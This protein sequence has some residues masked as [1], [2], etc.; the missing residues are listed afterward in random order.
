MATAKKLPSGSWRCQVYS[1]NEPVF[2][3]NGYPV[4]DP[5]TKRQKQKRIYVSF[6][7]D[8]PSKRGKAEAEHAAAEYQLN[9]GKNNSR[10]KQKSGNMT[11][12]NAM[13][14][15]IS[16]TQ[17]VLSG[18]TIQGYKKE[19]YDSYS[20]LMDKKLREITS[21]DLQYAVDMDTKRVSKRS[22]KNKKPISPKTVRNTFNYVLTVI[23]H[24]YPGD[25]YIVKLPTVPKKVKELL[26]AQTV[27]N[28]IKGTDIELPCLLACW[29][30]FSMSEIRGI[31]LKDISGDYI[32][33]NQV[34]VD[35][36]CT[37]T[38]KETGKAEPRLRKHRIPAYIK[39]LI[40]K[41]IQNAT[42]Q[43]DHLIKLSGHGIYMRWKRLLAQN[44]LPHIKF[45]D[46]RHLNASV[47]ALLRIPDKYAQERGG[48]ASDKV[49]KSVY[50]H[51]FSEERIKVDD[52]IDNYF[53]SLLGINEDQKAEEMQ[54]EDIIK[55]LKANNPDGWFEDLKKF[56]QHEMQHKK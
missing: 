52:T 49:M 47:M 45:H 27:I 19:Q 44:N 40:D 13:E 48:W 16:D 33:L 35:I 54:P 29:L 21:D 23:R 10:R 56:M 39:E 25:S 26:P 50:T 6:T 18:T 34:V 43:D 46:L 31:R 12:K 7:S 53:E 37:P 15:Y 11:L 32:T 3:S 9:K 14:Q 4:I 51:T 38:P 17:A 28:L 42:S 5:K 36:D 41:E 2:D 30:S 55:F 24:Y 8:D 22:K 20:F 1:H